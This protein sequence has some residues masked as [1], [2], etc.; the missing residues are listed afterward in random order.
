MNTNKTIVTYRF[1]IIFSIV[2]GVICIALLFLPDFDLLSLVLALAFLGGLIGGENSYEERDR[3]HFQQSYKPAFEWLLLVLLAAFAF[4]A[5]SKWFGFGEVAI[6]FLNNHWPSLIV[7]VMCI[8]LG[9][10]GL[11]K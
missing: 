4:I 6:V 3:Q 2:V 1:M 11:K 8:L 10:A 7:S 9:I 5:C